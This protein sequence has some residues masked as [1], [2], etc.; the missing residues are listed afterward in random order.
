VSERLDIGQIVYGY[1][2][3]RGIASH[4]AQKRSTNAAKSIYGQPNRTAHF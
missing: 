2:F 1:N 4:G 3:E